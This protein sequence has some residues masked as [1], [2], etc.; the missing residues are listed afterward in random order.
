MN[1]H[2]FPGT[3]S[4]WNPPLKVETLKTRTQMRLEAGN[5]PQDML[6]PCES[7][8]WHRTPTEG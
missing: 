1:G 6:K 5:A 8:E 7:A 3:M 2:L 4:M